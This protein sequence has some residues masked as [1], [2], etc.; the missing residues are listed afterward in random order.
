MKG[1][2]QLSIPLVG[3]LNHPPSAVTIA[4]VT[5]VLI[6]IIIIV[7]IIIFFGVFMWHKKGMSCK[8]YHM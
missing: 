6:I 2:Y 8:V 7:A 4:I 5:V 1:V 3:D